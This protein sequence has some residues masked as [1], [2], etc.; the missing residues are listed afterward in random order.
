MSKE[1]DDSFEVTPETET[2]NSFG[3]GEDNE[4]ARLDFCSEL[5]ENVNIKANTFNRGLAFTEKNSAIKQIH[6]TR[7]PSKN[8]FSVSFV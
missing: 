5:N 2:H 1:H 6:H 4:T 7:S 8:K 3:D